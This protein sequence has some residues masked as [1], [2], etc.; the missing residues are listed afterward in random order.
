MPTPETGAER[1]VQPGCSPDGRY[2]AVTAFRSGRWYLNVSDRQEETVLVERLAGEYSNLGYVT[3]L[4]E[5]LQYFWMGVRASGYFD[6]MQ[7]AVQT[8]RTWLI[9]QGKHPAVAPDGSRLVYFCGNLLHLCMF[10]RETNELLF[11]I[12]ISY[13]K[14]INEKNIPA[15]AAWSQ[16]GQWVYFSSSILGNW[17][18]YRMHP[19]GSQMQNLTEAWT[20]DEYMPAAR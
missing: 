8:D 18:V 20:S 15:T 1:A 9:G 4:P 3:F 7:T 10:E 13:F 2:L 11:Q 19:D 12:P 16:D 6:I 5:E 17:D 14:K